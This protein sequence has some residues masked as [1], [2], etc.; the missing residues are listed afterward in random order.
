MYSN[1]CQIFQYS[2]CVPFLIQVV[3]KQFL[4]L[5]QL[6]LLLHQGLIGLIGLHQ[7]QPQPQ[8]APVGKTHNYVAW[9]K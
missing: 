2:I 7:L 5:H 3:T 4:R 1:F 6:Q 9:E 8:L